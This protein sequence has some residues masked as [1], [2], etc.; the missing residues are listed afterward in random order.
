MRHTGRADRFLT[1]DQKSR[2]M[3]ATKAVE[4][5]TSGEVA[6]MVVDG[7]SQYREAEVIGGIFLGS[8]A[9]LLLT[10]VWLHGSLWY[11]I[12]LSFI[13]F[14]PARSLF[15]QIPI[16][17]V[18]LTGRRRREE[19]VRERALRAFYEKGL[20]RTVHH[21][22]IL[23]FISLLER[24]V[25]VLADKGIHEK[26]RQNTLNR[27][28]GIVSKGIHEDRAFES[29]MAAIAET[30]DLL[31]EHF[32]VGPGDKDELPDEVICEPGGECAE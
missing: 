4:K 25:W 3:E 11:Y 8:L 1:A 7:S 14:F 20:Y 24:K 9:A 23:Y 6:I 31:A 5:R 19:A 2:L 21:T 26:I 17:K 18:S 32:P 29:L 15:R 22:G 12:P 27:L 13:L 28:A 16:L 10:T 30:G